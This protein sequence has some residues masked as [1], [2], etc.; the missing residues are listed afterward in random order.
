[1]DK[2]SI[3][4]EI[5]FELLKQPIKLSLKDKESKEI[6]SELNI[7][8]G[9][10]RVCF[11]LATPGYTP[12][13]EYFLGFLLSSTNTT[14]LPPQYV[15]VFITDD[16]IPIDIPATVPCIASGYSTPISIKIPYN[17]YDSLRVS[18]EKS[19]DKEMA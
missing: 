14:Y 16:K 18:I 6:V 10:Y 11:E 12:I 19:S 3:D 2:N 5:T 8:V 17:P 7:G 9:L 13:G 1:M 4:S 15:P